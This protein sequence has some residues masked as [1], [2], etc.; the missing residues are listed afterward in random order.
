MKQTMN[1]YSTMMPSTVLKNEYDEICMP[2][3]FF[4]KVCMP[5]SK[6][7]EFTMYYR[8]DDIKRKA[9]EFYTVIDTLIIFIEQYTQL[10]KEK[11]PITKIMVDNL[12]RQ[13]WLYRTTIMKIKLDE[14]KKGFYISDNLALYCATLVASREMNKLL[15]GRYR[16]EFKKS[17][18]QYRPFDENNYK[19]TPISY[20]APKNE[21]GL[22][23]LECYIC[24]KY[25]ISGDFVYEKA[26][27]RAKIN[28]ILV[29]AFKYYTKQE[30]PSVKRISLSDEFNYN[31][32]MFTS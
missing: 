6:G 2:K 32:A 17:I 5:L 9:N 12:Y 16:N 22:S 13:V 19:I 30:L 4:E 18:E 11:K 20:I 29:F 7:E 21:R 3:R 25:H 8:N 28:A 31:Y 24:E 15:K 10:L 14:E 26:L 1:K 23:K 27:D